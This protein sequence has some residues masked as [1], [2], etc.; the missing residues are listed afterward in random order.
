MLAEMAQLKRENVRLKSAFDLQA[1]ESAELA[2]QVAC[3][4]D[5]AAADKA[6]EADKA[7]QIGEAAQ[8]QAQLKKEHVVL[9]A[10]LHAERLLSG[11]L[12]DQ[13]A[14]VSRQPTSDTAQ[15]LLL[16]VLAASQRPAVESG[17][18]RIQ[19]MRE[20]ADI[21]KRTL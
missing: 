13:F 6:V 4:R 5:A 16:Q 7:A 19:D 11:R 8:A 1:N 21:L 18:I 2:S 9:S 10:A 15:A 20:I 12:I 17:S 14:L 3:L